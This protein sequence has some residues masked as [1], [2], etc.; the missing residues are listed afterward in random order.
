MR[1]LIFAIGLLLWPAFV[2]GQSVYF[3]N[4]HSHTSYS[5]GSGMPCSLVSKRTRPGSSSGLIFGEERIRVDVP[6]AVKPVGDGLFAFRRRDLP[7]MLAHQACKPGEI[8]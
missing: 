3:G 1:R 2:A 4:L 8:L 5:D 6:I 7:P